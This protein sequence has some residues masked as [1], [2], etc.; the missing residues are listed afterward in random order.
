MHASGQKS[1]ETLLTIGTVGQI[2]IY[3]DV[4]ET[5]ERREKKTLQKILRNYSLWTSG[6]M[7][8][9]YLLI[10]IILHAV[11]SLISYRSYIRQSVCK[12]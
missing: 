2:H 9:R 11:H 4:A 7:W 8:G 1:R 5:D 6:A 12:R 10:P 3:H